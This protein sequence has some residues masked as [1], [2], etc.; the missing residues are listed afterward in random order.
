MTMRQ[1]SGPPAGH[2]CAAVLVSLQDLHGQPWGATLL[3]IG[4][5]PGGQRS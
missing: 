4:C 2:A 5:D 3:A 1:N